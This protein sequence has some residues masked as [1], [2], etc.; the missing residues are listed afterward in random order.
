LYDPKP[1]Y[2]SPTYADRKWQCSPH[3]RKGLADFQ[4]N[5]GGNEDES[6]DEDEEIGILREDLIPPE[7]W[8][9]PSFQLLASL[10]GAAGCD[11]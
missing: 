2:A 8:M 10:E 6:Q 1:T 11:C 5:C 3:E 4:G 7:H 9:T